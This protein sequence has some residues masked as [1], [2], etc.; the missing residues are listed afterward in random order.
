MEG[1]I[2]PATVVE[3]AARYGDVTTEQEVA[4]RYAN[5]RPGTESAETATG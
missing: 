3:L 2:E 1:A 4:A 5:P